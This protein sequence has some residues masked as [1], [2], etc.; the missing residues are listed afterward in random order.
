MLGINSHLPVAPARRPDILWG[1]Q[2]HRWRDKL[3]WGELRAD[4]SLVTTLAIDP[5]TPGTVYAGTSDGK[6]FGMTFAPEP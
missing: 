3:G 2:E 5:Q 1:I 6:V 4:N